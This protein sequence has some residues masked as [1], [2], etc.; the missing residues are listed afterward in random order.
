MHILKMKL[1]LKKKADKI[2]ND[3]LMNNVEETKKLKQQYSGTIL[4][5][6]VDI[7]N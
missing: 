7:E 2:Y 3:Y 5:N 1:K 4:D 6:I